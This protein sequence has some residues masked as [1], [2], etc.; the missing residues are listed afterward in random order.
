[1]RAKSEG[2]IILFTTALSGPFLPLCVHPFL[3][4]VRSLSCFALFIDHLLLTSWPKKSPVAIVLE[5]DHLA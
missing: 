4:C 3:M 1:M 5:V 2:H